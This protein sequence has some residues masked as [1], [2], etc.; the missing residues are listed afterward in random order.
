MSAC[1]FHIL[2]TKFSI[3]ELTIII[4]IKT[5]ISKF[6]KKIGTWND[7]TRECKLNLQLYA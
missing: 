1:Y 7:S 4:C 5:E 6:E 3:N 2:L